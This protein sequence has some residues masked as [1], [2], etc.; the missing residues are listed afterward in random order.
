MVVVF[1]SYSTTIPTTVCS[2]VLPIKD[3]CNIK[4][5]CI[6]DD[7]INVQVNCIKLFFWY[8]RNL[9][10]QVL[11]KCK[12][13]KPQYLLLQLLFLIESQIYIWLNKNIK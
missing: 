5:N 10:L 12:I 1:I 6:N 13:I 4:H 11:R 2:S 3:N 8:S 9:V 7:R